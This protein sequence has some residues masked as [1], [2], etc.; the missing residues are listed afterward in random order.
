[1]NANRP[2]PRFIT[3]EL[4]TPTI[5]R[6]ADRHLFLG[7]DQHLAI[8][9]RRRGRKYLLSI[10]NDSFYISPGSI[11]YVFAVQIFLNDRRSIGVNSEH[12]RR[13]GEEKTKRRTWHSGTSQRL[14]CRSGKIRETETG[15]P[16]TVFPFLATHLDGLD[17]GWYPQESSTPNH[18]SL[19]GNMF[20]RSARLI[21]SEDSP[22]TASDV[23]SRSLYYH[24]SSLTTISSIPYLCHSHRN[25]SFT[26]T[27]TLPFAP[28]TT[29]PS[30]VLAARDSPILVSS[31]KFK[32][33]PPSNT[34][35]ADHRFSRR[36][37]EQHP[38]VS[39][40]PY[41]IRKIRRKSH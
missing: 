11:K 37:R 5:L 25:I 30:R 27:H 32:S 40:F 2:N 38:P 20:E 7:I 21:P 10:I 28:I 31:S 6:L 14:A 41:H 12:D 1:M 35:S 24:F 19:R 22:P 36:G 33:T 4:H 26:Q 17:S 3:P 15:K 29:V 34:G 13:A 16:K 39:P 8:D 18:R 23:L 9:A